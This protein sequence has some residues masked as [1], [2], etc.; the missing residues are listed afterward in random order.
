MHHLIAGAVAFVAIFLKGFQQQNVTAKRYGAIAVTSY[1]MAFA[2]V[3]L[4][5]LVVRSGW[6]IAIAYGTGGTLGMMVAV[7]MHT[8]IFGGKQNA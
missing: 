6:D 2:D 1:L 8:K 4:V 7:S 3:A 5:G